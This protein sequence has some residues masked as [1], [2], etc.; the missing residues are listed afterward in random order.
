MANVT[1]SHNQPWISFV[2]LFQWL[3]T[4]IARTHTS[5][6]IVLDLQNGNVF[7]IEG[8]DLVWDDALDNPFVSGTMTAV[9]V[10]DT[11]SAPLLSI[12]DL[13]AD[14]NAFGE[15]VMTNPDEHETL[16][17]TARFL[18][19]GD[20]TIIGGVSND[21]LYP[22][23][24]DDS[25]YGG[26]GSD[27]V[28][29]GPGAA[30]IDGGDGWDTVSF[31]DNHASYPT[32]DTG[33]SIDLS[34][35]TGTNRDG[36]TLVISNVEDVTGSL[37]HDTIVGDG[38]RN[39]LYGYAGDDSIFGSGGDDWL[40]GGD[41]ND[42]LDGGEGD[43]EFEIGEWSGTDY[44]SG[45][46]LLIGGEGHDVAYLYTPS[47]FTF[48]FNG[49]GN[50]VFTEKLSGAT[51]TLSEIEAIDDGSN[52]HTVEDFRPVSIAAQ[53][54]SEDGV[55]SFALPEGAYRDGTTFTVTD[56]DGN[57]LP[58]WISFD[59]G[60][61]TFTGTPPANWNGTV[62]IRV[63]AD[64]HGIE[65]V[66]T[67]DLDVVA[68]NDAPTSLTLSG[69]TILENASAGTEVAVLGA[70]DAEGD[71]L[72]YSLVDDAGGR[73]RIDGNRIVVADGSKLDYEWGTSHSVTVRVIDPSGAFTTRTFEIEVG[74][75]ANE[76]ATGSD[77]S[78][79]IYVG[80]GK[81]N[82]DG[83]DGVDTVS[84]GGDREG[85]PDLGSGVSIELST[86]T[87]TNRDGSAIAISNVEN[88]F[89]ST[90]GDNIGGDAGDNVID[91]G[92]G[93]DYLGGGEG[94]D[95][96]LG[97]EGDDSL[98][99]DA[100]DD[101][102]SGGA[103]D[104]YL[105]GSE[106]DDTLNGGEGNDQFELGETVYQNGQ[107]NF[108]TGNKLLIG[109]AGEDVANI[110]VALSDFSYAFNGDGNI[111]FT[112]KASGGTYTLSGI[113]TIDD[114]I[115]NYTVDDFRPVSIATQSLSE[116]G[117][118]SFVLP[119][120]AY[121]DGTTFTVTALEGGPLPDWLS[122]DVATRSFTGTPPA[123]WNGTVGIRV[124]TNDRGIEKASSF[125]LVVE[126]VNDAP[127]S[128][129]LSGG[130]ILENSFAGTQVA[131][132]HAEDLDDQTLTYSLVDD[133]GG[134]FRIDGN[135][136]VVADGTKLDYEQATSHKVTVKV[137]DKSGAFTTE[138][139]TVAVGDV[140]SEKATGGTGNDV[141][142]G[143]AGRDVIGG[144]LG[145][146]VLTGGKGKDAFVFNTKA[147]KSN[148][149]KI[150]DFSVK[151]DSI[152]LDNKYFT[153]LGKKGS[154]SSP[155]KLNKEFFTIGS[156]AKEKDD[157]LVYDNKK[158]VLYYD[159]DGSGKGKAVEIANL[160]K[161]LKMTY[162]DF[163]VI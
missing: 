76:Q 34:A 154:E 21:V 51:Y 133:A 144:G 134:R 38:A 45:N 116:D 98:Y 114:G 119:E 70:D 128:L 143:G 117:V 24:G 72:T 129:A 78:D 42:T 95:T 74:D 120:G 27:F 52:I 67:F 110:Y 75:V 115:N 73:F 30:T 11:N 159:A 100:G 87:G 82:I 43:D 152:H 8:T 32:Y 68:V 89:G 158:G 156:K 33:V 161:N 61:R 153:K 105:Y 135:R 109:G 99:G 22:G 10:T 63:T 25:I 57:P 2:S 131:A 36:S 66:S 7:T 53:S 28:Y 155:A 160:S 19:S 142:K 92:A 1:I 12:T 122:F 130:T 97:G 121:R 146:D 140:A 59:V 136:I 55:W 69:G 77:G 47:D 138:T 162:A 151:D 6:G 107:L 145:K 127:T 5:D 9:H 125:N 4:G 113:E 44:Y 71:A 58:T 84:F 90:G 85:Y 49:D 88:V 15:V 18:L 104:D 64:D 3:S 14:A 23:L 112:H 123:N 35:G 17:N 157:Y 101:S 65:K 81:V 31:A 46:K 139:F 39:S 79:R 148:V 48:A 102:V 96:L 16:T 126:A 147:S 13:S 62:G 29:V 149:D 124:T 106:G 40:Y 103:G 60:T 111:V 37:G 50:L 26:L 80:L 108:A 150:A 86:G 41:G 163:F 94:N 137:T 141:I 91:G 118:W 54:I 56:L 20:D 93:D 132:L 83:G